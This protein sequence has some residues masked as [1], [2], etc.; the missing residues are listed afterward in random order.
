MA[1]PHFHYRTVFLSDA[2]LG[3]RACEGRALSDFIKHL[4]CERLY[5]VGDIVD[6]WRLKQRWYWP[7][8]HNMVVR[9]ILKQAKH[10]ENVFLI[11]GNHDEGARQFYNMDFGGIRVLPYAVHVTADGRKLLVTHGDQFDLVVRHSKLVSMLGS[12][13]YDTLVVANRWYNRWRQKTGRPY[14]SLSKAIKGKVKSACMFISRFEETLMKEAERREADGVV[15]GHIHQPELRED[16]PIAYYNCGDWVENCTAVVEHVDGRMEVINGTDKV[17][18][19]LAR[20]EPQPETIDEDELESID[21][22]ELIRWSPED[23]SMHDSAQLTFGER[24]TADRST[25]NG[26]ADEAQPAQ[27]VDYRL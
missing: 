19:L 27:P 24:E 2:H 12:R 10:C 14:V 4:R 3:S 8:E 6:M 16:G 15:C 21:V 9:R 11:P 1:H 13:A 26:H 5:L 23:M 18:E 22:A 20:H 17:A 7:A 25:A